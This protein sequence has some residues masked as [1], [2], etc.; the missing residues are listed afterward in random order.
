[1]ISDAVIAALAGAIG[2]AVV[3]FV[4]SRVSDWFENRARADTPEDDKWELYTLLTFCDMAGFVQSVD[5]QETPEYQVL[6]AKSLNRLSI[7]SINS[8]KDSNNYRP[9]F[10]MSHYRNVIIPHLIHQ[11]LVLGVDY[12]NHFVQQ[13]VRRIWKNRLRYIITA[14]AGRLIGNIVKDYQDFL[15]DKQRYNKRY[16]LEFVHINPLRRDRVRN[17]IWD[18]INGQI[19]KLPDVAKDKRESEWQRLRRER[20]AFTSEVWTCEAWLIR[21]YRERV[22]EYLEEQRKIEKGLVRI[23]GL[24]IH[25]PIEEERTTKKSRGAKEH[26]ER[27]DPPTTDEIA[28]VTWHAIRGRPSG[29]LVEAYGYYVDSQK[30]CVV[31]DEEA[32]RISYASKAEAPSINASYHELRE[33]LQKH[34]PETD[35]E[36]VLV[37]D[38]ET[39]R[40]KF[41]REHI[42]SSSSQASSVVLGRVSSGPREWREVSSEDVSIVEN[43]ESAVIYVLNSKPRGIDVEAKGYFGE[44]SGF[45]VIKGS[46]AAVDEA[47]SISAVYQQLRAKLV[48]ENILVEELGADRY[49]FSEDHKFSSSSQASSVVLGRVSSG[50]REWRHEDNPSRRLGAATP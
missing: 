8:T 14:D 44:V 42:F 33:K 28:D 20:D 45:V 11:K 26:M 29:V 9:N 39:S 27:P 5:D 50:P 48:A 43:V 30:F 18:E 6:S 24:R 34:D 1:M 7:A 22:K 32:G 46:A 37:P 15:Y 49:V 2:G 40:L 3:G 47:A 10:T 13:W 31:T 19:E 38:D 36:P 35:E 25:E 16:E 41:T 23:H 4:I 12:K 17:Y 21:L